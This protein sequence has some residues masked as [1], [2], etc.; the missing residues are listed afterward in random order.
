MNKFNNNRIINFLSTMESTGVISQEEVLT[1]ES[2]I[3]EDL[4]TSNLSIKQLTETPSRVGYEPVHS[5]ISSYINSEG[6]TLRGLGTMTN[7]VEELLKLESMLQSYKAAMV[8]L[9]SKLTSEIIYN[10]RNSKTR[11]TFIDSDGEERSLLLDALDN[12]MGPLGILMNSNY[13]SDVFN[14][15]K[16]LVNVTIKRHLPVGVWVL[17]C[18]YKSNIMCNMLTNIRNDAL[19]TLAGLATPIVEDT[20]GSHCI[21][22]LEKLPTAI[23]CIT[24]IITEVEDY[25]VAAIAAVT[26]LSHPDN[27]CLSHAYKTTRKAIAILD[28]DKLTLPYF[29]VLTQLLTQ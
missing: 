21:D 29:R 22:A 28:K 19:T 16:D 10:L 3:G 11:K 1:L 5:I 6:L 25:K 7:V 2:S 18:E 27:S 20:T 4:V 15:D 26:D 13:L 8:E 12:D 9:N 24:S 17:W 14:V 23:E